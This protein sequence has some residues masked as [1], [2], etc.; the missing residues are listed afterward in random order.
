MK[1]RL[2]PLFSQRL[3]QSSSLYVN[4]KH[5]SLETLARFQQRSPIDQLILVID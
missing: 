5:A 2:V 4:V 1:V 3:G